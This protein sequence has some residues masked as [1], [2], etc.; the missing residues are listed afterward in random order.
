MNQVKWGKKFKLSIEWKKR[1]YKSV[2]ST[3][4]AAREE[5]M[6]GKV[7]QFIWSECR[8]LDAAAKEKKLMVLKMPTDCNCKWRVE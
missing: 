5:F 4:D 1:E 8:M 2:E 6:G 3:F 7:W